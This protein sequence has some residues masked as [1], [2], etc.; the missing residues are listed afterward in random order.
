M[1]RGKNNQR[2]PKR[3]YRG[4]SREGNYDG[5][6]GKGTVG[7]RTAGHNSVQVATLADF[8]SDESVGSPGKEERIV[9]PCTPESADNIQELRN[10]VLP[11]DDNDGGTTRFFL[12]TL[13]E[14]RAAACNTDFACL[15]AV[16]MNALKLYLKTRLNTATEAASLGD[17]RFVPNRGLGRVL[18]WGSRPLPCLCT[19]RLILIVDACSQRLYYGDVV[20]H[21]E[22]TIVLPFDPPLAVRRNNTGV[23]YVADTG[24]S[25]T[26]FL[27]LSAALSSPGQ[28]ILANVPSR[29]PSS[30]LK[31]SIFPEHERLSFRTI[32]HSGT[33]WPGEVRILDASQ[34][35]AL[36]SSITRAISVILAPSGCGG[37]RL[38]R[39]VIMLLLENY[40]I[41]FEE[42]RPLLV[43][44]EKAE[45]LSLPIPMTHFLSLADDELG[46]AEEKAVDCSLQ[47]KAYVDANLFVARGVMSAILATETRALHQD[48]L[49]DFTNAFDTK[50]G[51]QRNYVEEWLFYK[52]DR[53]E[54]KGVA[55]RSEVRKYKA[56]CK[57]QGVPSTEVCVGFTFERS[58]GQCVV[59]EGQA[60]PSNWEQLRKRVF[61]WKKLQTTQ[62]SLI[63]A[64]NIYKLTT[65]DRWKLYKHWVLCSRTK[66]EEL[67]RT[68]SE[69]ARARSRLY[70][71]AVAKKT[72][73]LL[74][75]KP[76]LFAT[77]LAAVE[78][79]S[80]ISAL[81]PRILVAYGT[82]DL[83]LSG[84]ISSS[85]E[86]VVLIIDDLDVQRASSQSWQ[87]LYCG[88]G[89]VA[90]HELN[91]QY[92]APQ[93]VCDILEAYTNKKV[94]CRF[95]GSCPIS[96]MGELTRFFTSEDRDAAILMLVRLAGFLQNHGYNGGTEALA[97][98]TMGS[99]RDETLCV[100]KAFSL[101]GISFSVL[102]ISV[103]YP[104][105]A[106]IVLF[107]ASAESSRKTLAAA[108][109]RSLCAVYG[110]FH[111]PSSAGEIH[112]VVRQSRHLTQGVLT[113]QCARHPENA[114][115]ISSAEDFG[116]KLQNNGCCK[117][118]CQKRLP[119]GHSCLEPCH[120]GDHGGSACKEP[121]QQ[122]VCARGHV[123]PNVCFE[124]CVQR[125]EALVSVQLRGCG[126]CADVPCHLSAE[127]SFPNF[128]CK[129][130][131]SIM[132]ACGHNGEVRCC[133][134]KL[135][136]CTGAKRLPDP[137]GASER[138]VQPCTVMVPTSLPDCG[139]FAE[140][141]CSSA[142]QDR[143]SY[144]CREFGT[145]L[146]CGHPASIPCFEKEQYLC[147]VVVTKELGCG[148]TVTRAC[149]DK[150]MCT[151][152]VEQEL[153]CGHA[154]PLECW[155]KTTDYW[156][157]I[158]CSVKV[159]T[160]LPNCEHYTDFPCSTKDRDRL[161]YQCKETGAVLD[162]G[163]KA[164][165]L[166]YM[167]E[168]FRCERMVLKGLP[169]GHTVTRGC[170]DDSSACGEVEKELSCKH[171]VRVQC[172]EDVSKLSCQE[173]VRKSYGCGH[174]DYRRCS[175]N[176]GCRMCCSQAVA[177][178]GHPCTLICGHIVARHVCEPC[179]KKCCVS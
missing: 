43:V 126:H 143:L 102:P 109:S 142:E 39:T 132:M 63:M 32:G 145:T 35:A 82:P 34:Y 108:V 140:F 62:A 56:Y 60:A 169:C 144:R 89:G 93:Q 88:G 44:T 123:C 69:E 160:R 178:C 78:Q 47:E 149:S 72:A 42:Q 175:D 30:L 118:P 54:I 158:R 163:H 2:R 146:P 10:S 152:R 86:Q 159:R 117:E 16:A 9:V 77:P 166:C 139:H 141:P 21:G 17:Y 119:C 114:I 101:Y 161:F 134:V 87:A 53:E 24:I 6:S 57:A 147:G 105:Y 137:H 46:A 73:S 18:C 97:V 112:N 31:S 1:S 162:C 74:K 25:A 94:L 131:V 71:V 92:L 20:L 172:G 165:I 75:G 96:G 13:S 33:E 177:R 99:S 76:V 170:S 4:K 111:V 155:Q 12:P 171:K 81:R 40:R 51:Q 176:C 154:V 48:E 23:V 7:A 70:H 55:T 150:T 49:K 103:F 50:V 64:S 5:A 179:K 133:D 135:Y 29:K 100:E 113:L 36:R 66:H 151:I 52:V 26:S 173:V 68:V 128:K 136:S 14:V 122:I 11:L 58:S 37:T 127:R 148:H 38:V 79:R 106:R 120:A 91:V 84:I 22:E 59:T 98:L 110:F 129:E 67:L 138:V 41:W 80:V 107:Y 125:C 124:T 174:V 28:H 121:C 157:S 115:V 156:K 3:N 167:R 168:H 85:V 45:R 153:P 8:S 130:M 116:V 90:L 15:N 61:L 27:E 83:Q 19:G 65:E 164:P 95:P 104:R